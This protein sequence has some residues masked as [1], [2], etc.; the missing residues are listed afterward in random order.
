M[1]GTPFDAIVEMYGD[2]LPVCECCGED[3]TDDCHFT[4]PG[5]QC[6]DCHSVFVGMEESKA[7]IY[8]ADEL[9]ITVPFPRFDSMEAWSI[10]PDEYESGDR[11]SNTENAYRT[12]CRHEN[13]N[14]DQLIGNL[15]TDCEVDQIKYAAIREA[16]DQLVNEEI[17]A[18]DLIQ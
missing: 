9:K 2:D 18:K 8:A 5:Y 14:Y 11:V 3:I 15:S 10:S 16:A 7:A 17:E 6:Q 12:R 4:D 1:T 13:T